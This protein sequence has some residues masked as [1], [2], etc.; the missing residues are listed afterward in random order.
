MLKRPEYKAGALFSSRD[1]A[2]EQEYRWQHLRRHNRYLHGWGVVCG[3]LVVPVPDPRRPWAL[4]VCPGYAISPCGDEIEVCAA[5]TIDLA[6][7]VWTRPVH[8]GKPAAEAYIAIRAAVDEMNPAPAARPKGA[9]RLC[10]SFRIEV[11]W[12]VPKHASVRF[13]LCVGGVAP[14]PVLPDPP[15]VL[16]AAVILPSSQRTPLA[17]V[18]QLR[19]P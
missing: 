15:V 16:L 6:D 8:R 19:R 5:V 4:R 2:D 14:C 1:L 13:D 10:D 18:Q 17:N 12:E 7:Y 9:A 3:L 11:L